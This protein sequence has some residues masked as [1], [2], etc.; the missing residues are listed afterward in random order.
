MDSYW[1]N[2]LL[3]AI[4]RPLE[5]PAG[6]F[7]YFNEW[8]NIEY[9]V[10]DDKL[11]DIMFL[12]L[13]SLIR[14]QSSV[15]ASSGTNVILFWV[16]AG[17]KYPGCSQCPI[18]IHILFLYAYFE[19]LSA[20]RID[21]FCYDGCLWVVGLFGLSTH[22]C[23]QGALHFVLEHPCHQYHLGMDPLGPEQ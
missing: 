10:M 23:G 8:M 5:L 22:L 19:F 12:A 16:S 17:R 1:K 11:I 14:F 13:F 2:S 21:L 20:K 3:S 15:S 7:V 18:G 4:L 9:S 6:T